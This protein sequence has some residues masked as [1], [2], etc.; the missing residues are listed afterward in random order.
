MQLAFW[1]PEDD[2]KVSTLPS[3]TNDAGD[4]VSDAQNCS[5]TLLSEQL[6]LW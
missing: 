5:Q 1:D 3:T 4:V 2:A 6:R